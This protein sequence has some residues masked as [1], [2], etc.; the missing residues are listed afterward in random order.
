[1]SDIM[2]KRFFLFLLIPVLANFVTTTGQAQSTPKKGVEAA[3][4]ADTE[5]VLS[6]RLGGY[7]YEITVSE[8]ES[9][10]AEQ[11]LVIFDCEMH[12]AEKNRVSAERQGALEKLKANRRLSE[13][14]SV[15][16]LDLA[17]AQAEYDRLSAEVELTEIKIKHCKIKA[18]F[19]GVVIEKIVSPHQIVPE[20]EALLRVLNLDDLKIEFF[21]PSSSLVDIEVGNKMN[22]YVQERQQ[23]YPFIVQGVVPRVDPVSQT[24]KVIGKFEQQYEDLIPGMS[25]IVNL[26]MPEAETEDEIESSRASK[27]VEPSSSPME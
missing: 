25:G 5:T 7:I 3:I 11:D 27:E 6:S 16:K 14:N 22:I 15:S 26:P 23:D 13:L 17:V 4:A 1:M 19:D 10:V 2:F 18:P 20:G 12:E 21:V 8:G 9:F 24:F